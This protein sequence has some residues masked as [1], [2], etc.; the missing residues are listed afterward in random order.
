[1]LGTCAKPF[2]ALRISNDGQTAKP[3]RRSLTA[4][5]DHISIRLVVGTAICH[6]GGKH[7]E[8]GLNGFGR[9]L[10]SHPA[11]CCRLMRLGR[12]PAKPGVITMTTIEEKRR[13]LYVATKT[14]EAAQARML[15]VI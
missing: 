9:Q 3:P 14:A 4:Q 15:G 1:M 7:Q 5:R 10:R 13:A 2:G 11:L 6:L 8:S 12:A